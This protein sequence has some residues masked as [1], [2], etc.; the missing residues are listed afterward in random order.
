[1]FHMNHF[2]CSLQLFNGENELTKKYL[3][4]VP[5]VTCSNLKRNNSSSNLYA[6]NSIEV[7]ILIKRRENFTNLLSCGDGTINQ[8]ALTKLKAPLIMFAQYLN[9]KLYRTLC[10]ICNCYVFYISELGELLFSEGGG[11]ISVRRTTKIHRICY[12]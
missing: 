7:L 1:M 4:P 10:V 6:I 3:S 11:K 9:Y 2:G 5:R 12:K 8:S